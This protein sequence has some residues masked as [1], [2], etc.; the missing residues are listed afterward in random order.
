MLPEIGRGRVPPT[1]M[2]DYGD[3]YRSLQ[4]QPLLGML[5][6]S[7]IFADVNLCVC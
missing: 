4:A 7:P 2:S 6:K 3:V 5:T 1:G